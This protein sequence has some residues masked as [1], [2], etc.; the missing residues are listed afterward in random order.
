MELQRLVGPLVNEVYDAVHVEGDDGFLAFVGFQEGEAEGGI[1]KSVFGKYAGGVGVLEDVEGGFQVRVSIGV[2]GAEFV[3]G[4]VLSGGFV[5]AGGQLVGLSVTGEGVGAP[6]S[7]IVPHQAAAGC[8][9]VDA[10]NEGVV[11]LVA[12]TN[13]YPVDPAAALFE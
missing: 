2:V 13:R 7:G 3:A 9:D 10:D 12:V 11:R 5:Q 8:V 4:E 1:H 6:A